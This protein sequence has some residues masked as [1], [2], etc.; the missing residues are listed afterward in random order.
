MCNSIYII[1][2]H[3]T[4][5]ETRQ[6]RSD[7]HNK[8]IEWWLD[9]DSKIVIRILA[10][11]FVEVSFGII[12]VLNI[13]IGLIVLS[14][15]LVPEMFYSIISM[16]QMKPGLYLQIQMLYLTYI[17]TLF[18]PN[19]ICDI[20]RSFPE[21]FADVDLFWPHWDGRRAMGLSTIS[22]IMLDKDVDW[23]DELCFDSKT[24]THEGYSILSKEQ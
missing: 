5:P 22:L 2:Y 21:N 1:A 4:D 15:L 3:G 19:N 11:D 24:N 8:Q 9:Y 17:Q 6:I 13:L 10:Q 23:S 18:I 20:L 7:N 12:L 14:R 16:T